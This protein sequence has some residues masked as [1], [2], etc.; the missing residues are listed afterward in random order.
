M[1]E[2]CHS[3]SR[4]KR[5]PGQSAGRIRV[6]LC[7]LAL[8]WMQRTSCHA[9]GATIA[10]AGAGAAPACQTCH[11]AVGE[12]MTQAQREQVSAHDTAWPVAAGP[13][14]AQSTTGTA[15]AATARM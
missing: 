12:G 6:S 10:K 9:N 3:A 13:A 1:T 14:N 8:G 11:G 7:G 2:C 5:L 4:C 15:D